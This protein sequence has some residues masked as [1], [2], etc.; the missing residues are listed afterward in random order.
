[1]T[2]PTIQLPEGIPTYTS[3]HVTGRFVA[4][5]GY[6]PVTIFF[7][8]WDLFWVCSGA[9]AFVLGTGHR[10][11]IETGDF[12][13]LPPLV[14]ARV[15]ETREVLEFYFCHFDF[16]PVRRG[17]GEWDGPDCRGPG[18]LSR[19]PVRVRQEEAPGVV[20]AYER[21]IKAQEEARSGVRAGFWRIESAVIELIGEVAVFGL[22]EHVGP[23]IGVGTGA[24]GVA[25]ARI[26]KLLSR[27]DAEP[28]RGW[29]VDGLAREV[30]MTAGHL[31]ALS[32]KVL[33]KGIKQH[34]ID[35]RLRLAVRLL[36]PTATGM[37]RSVK[38]VSRLAG[39]TSQHYLSRLFKKRYR[40]TPREFQRSG[41]E[42]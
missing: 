36:R 18:A 9:G 4:A 37:T 10:V 3:N 29:R 21:L 20:K 12:V 13:L 15:E 27:I 33:G 35:A 32:M 5:R 23:V 17:R 25:D 2:I 30:G 19:V 28:A 1:M 42:I 14:S 11:E 26:V 6:L 39:F 38:E 7:E 22:K 31:H 16:R 34:I 8:D 40:I 41:G 24:A